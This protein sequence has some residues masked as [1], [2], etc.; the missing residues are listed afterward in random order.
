MGR[1]GTPRISA[2]FK[3]NSDPLRRAFAVLC[4]K[5]GISQ[6]ARLREL[7][8]LDVELGGAVE[9]HKDDRLPPSL[10]TNTL[11]M[12]IAKEYKGRK[13]PQVVLQECGIEKDRAYEILSGFNK[14]RLPY[15][16]PTERGILRGILNRSLEGKTL[17]HFIDE[18]EGNT[19]TE[20]TDSP[21]RVPVES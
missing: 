7:I 6:S 13:S 8:A 14:D 18:N 9:F 10:Y 11:E 4:R 12:A 2:Y 21:G 15:L 16:S 17:E 1:K 5:I 3:K 20:P 19:I